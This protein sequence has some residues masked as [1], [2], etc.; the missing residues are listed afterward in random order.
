MACEWEHQ[1]AKYPTLCLPNLVG[2]VLVG[3]SLDWA[4]WAHKKGTGKR[5]KGSID[6][7]NCTTNTFPSP[8]FPFLH[9]SLLPSN[10]I[11]GFP[12]LAPLPLFVTVR[13]I[14][15]P[16]DGCSTCTVPVSGGQREGGNQP[17]QSN[18]GAARACARGAQSALGHVRLAASV[19]PDAACA[20]RVTTLLRFEVLGLCSAAWR[21]T[22][23]TSMMQCA[24]CARCAG[25][26]LNAVQSLPQGPCTLEHKYHRHLRRVLGDAGV[27]GLP[28]T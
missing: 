20:P 19:N 4:L 11:P 6:Q 25:G 21:K 14:S 10:P 13:S 18:Q 23:D 7:A 1:L 9:S 5:G 24:R 3:G 26:T 12:S 28:V 8:P 17:N 2:R 15:R 27:Y 22:Q 16:S